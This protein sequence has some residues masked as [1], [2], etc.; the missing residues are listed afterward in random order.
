LPSEE[1]EKK[2][3]TIKNTHTLLDIHLHM[4]NIPSN[5]F[6]VEFSKKRKFVAAV[7]KHKKYY[8]RNLKLGKEI[9][10]LE[11]L[12]PSSQDVLFSRGPPPSFVYP[13]K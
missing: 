9:I 1:E 11:H 13:P 7:A 6:L 3:A 4:V 10:L 2:R 5:T 8:C 12:F